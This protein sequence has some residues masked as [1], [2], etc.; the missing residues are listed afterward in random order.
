[1]LLLLLLPF[2]FVIPE[3]NLRF[4]RS[5]TNSKGHG[6]SRAIS[7]LPL[8]H[9]ERRDSTEKNLTMT[10]TPQPE[11]GKHYPALDGIRGF[12]FLLVFFFHYANLP[13]GFAGV[14]LFFVLSG[15]LITGILY[16]TRDT[17]HRLWNFYIRR[18]L[19]IFPL[20]YA[21]W[22]GVLVAT[23]FVHYSL[24]WGWLAW[25]LFVGNW[26]KLL[27]PVQPLSALWMLVVGALPS[28]TSPHAT[29]LFGPLWS[30]CVE[31]QFYLLWPWVIFKVR[32]I[33]KLAAL[34]LTCIVLCPL[35]RAFAAHH[36]PIGIGDHFYDS[37]T[38]LRIDG[39]LYGALIALVHRGLASLQ[40]LQLLARIAFVA[41]ASVIVGWFVLHPFV[42]HA[43]YLTPPCA[44]FIADL[45]SASVL[46][47]TLAPS[48]ILQ[49]FF[50]LF[51][52]RW[53][54]RISYGAYVFHLLFHAQIVWIV[55]MFSHSSST[56]VLTTLTALV[57][58][59]TLATAS[60]HLLELPFLRRKD[61]FS[62]PAHGLQ[63]S[64]PSSQ[65]PQLGNAHV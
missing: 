26:L 10:A 46:A 33:R 5:T 38:P 7:R 24:T 2:L 32:D 42:R 57:F 11:N 21:I 63:L 44:I 16:D 62:R 61:R 1:L 3:G 34:C 52:L 41:S 9:I 12:A 29:L 37:I 59:L 30:L 48:S 51:A 6:F 19:R 40:L 55:G 17:P 27:H 35:L 58:T 14:N 31:E 54:G 8:K 39:L 28:R 20:F 15:F 50:N 36:A 4:A 43:L 56:A 22:L 23:P 25:P 47:L 53:V 64:A 18:I 65:V 60:Y 13:W 45:A 49:S